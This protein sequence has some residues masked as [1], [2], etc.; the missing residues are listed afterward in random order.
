MYPQLLLNISKYVNLSSDEQKLFETFWTKKTLG[1]GD[2]LLRNGEV[3][4]T[5][6]FVVQGALK[7]FY[8]NSKNGKEEILY[9]A[10]DEWWATDI[11]SFRKQRPSIYNIQAINETILLQIRYTSFQDMLIQIPKLERF[12]RIIL[13]NY[14]GS[15][16][17]RIIL[18][19]VWDAEQRYFHFLDKYS[20]IVGKVPQYLIA[21]YLGFSP[22]FLSRIRKKNSSN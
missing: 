11:E 19:N 3:C 15:L 14:L 4:R 18:N 17:K 6:N 9:L 7:A 20:I 1:K 5:D 2:Y 16:Q 22:E 10:I 12:F 21:S 13:E 8:I